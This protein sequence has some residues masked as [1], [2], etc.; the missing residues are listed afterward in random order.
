[1]GER[2]CGCE[3]GEKKAEGFVSGRGSSESKGM[4]LFRD[5]VHCRVNEMGWTL[6]STHAVL[7]SRVSLCPKGSPSSSSA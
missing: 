5:Q 2:F 1:M 7:G 3:M 4:W 6:P